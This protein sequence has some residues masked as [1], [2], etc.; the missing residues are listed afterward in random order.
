MV[1]NKYLVT[2]KPAR[3]HLASLQ[4]STPENLWRELKVHVAQ[5]QPRNITGLEE[6]CMEKWTKIPHTVCANLVKTYRKLS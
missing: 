6:I 3:F 2:H 1:E 4:T 5:R